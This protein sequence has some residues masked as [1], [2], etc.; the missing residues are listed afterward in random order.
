MMT[1][2]RHPKHDFTL[3]IS[4]GN[5]TIGEWLDTE[6]RYNTRGISRLELYDLR[7]HKNIFTNN[8]I[9]QILAHASKN[10]N[11]RPKGNKTALLVSESIQYGLSRMYGSLAEIE[12][13]ENYKT[14][15]FYELAEAIEWLGEEVKDVLKGYD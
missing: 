8:E 10:A 14:G 3:F 11:I 6:G 12:G 2:T 5:T 1:Y 7:T 9:E 13:I 4:T 15:V